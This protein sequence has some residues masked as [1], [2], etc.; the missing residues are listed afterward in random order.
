MKRLAN[1]QCFT[2]FMSVLM[3]CVAVRSQ[4]TADFYSKTCPTLPQI[5]RKVVQ[6]AIKVEMR[7]AA[8]L[9][10]LHFHDC[11]V[12]GCDGSIL[13]DGTDV[14]KF[15]V[16]NINSARGFEVVDAIKSAVES[17]CSGVVS[18]ADILALA[19]RDSTLLSGGP[20]WKVLLGRRD[21]MV[22]SQ[23]QANLSLPSPFEGLNAI[24]AKFAAVGLNITDV[25]SLSGSHTIGLAKCATFSNRL[26][27]FSGTG[28]PDSTLDSNMLS[29]LQSLCPVNGDGN[30]TTAFDRNS[31]DLFDNHYFQNLINNKG[32]LGSDQILYSSSEA[33]STTK[34]IVE[35][36]S[37][38]SKLFFNDFANSMIK[39]GNISPLTGSSGE[40]RKNCR[41]VNS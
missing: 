30:K 12:N 16:A 17:Q 14:E 3:L 1:Y 8:S 2:L 23:A 36:Y 38:N 13:L 20:S 27:N 18:C 26:F 32:L 34:S 24:I 11:F 7:M 31:T 4:L 39:M 6:N 25:V 5:V 40:I 33:V 15:S 37:S 35:S 10:R 21:G 9:L 28:A 22:S 29:D 19:A 41:V